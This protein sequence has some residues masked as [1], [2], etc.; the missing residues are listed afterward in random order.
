MMKMYRRMPRF[1]VF[2]VSVCLT[3]M[4]IASG[5]AVKLISGYDEA[6]DKAV[7]E[8]Q[9]K[10]ETHLATLESVDGLPECT[11]ENHKQ[12]YDQAKM[13]IN[14]IAVRAAAIPKNSIITKEIALLSSNLDNFEKLHK[15]S[16]LSTD[17]ITLVRS[18]FNTS[19]TAIHKQLE[20][21]KRGG[22]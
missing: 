1:T 11:Y 10:M 9:Q 4:L 20:F 14:A 13:D 7:T 15:I 12:F 18:H 3:V 5:C 16:C 22:T 2:L 6:T 19:Y 21:A 8:L 17:Q